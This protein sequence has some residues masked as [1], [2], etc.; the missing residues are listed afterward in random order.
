MISYE[1]SFMLWRGCAIFKMFQSF[2]QIIT[3]TYVLI[4]NLFKERL[5]I[6]TLELT[7]CKIM[8]S[9]GNA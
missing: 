2:D 1:A 6:M 4:D 3:V 7:F 9:I 5:H 8:S